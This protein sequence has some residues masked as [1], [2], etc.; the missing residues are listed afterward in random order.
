MRPARGRAPGDGGPGRHVRRADRGARSDAAEGGGLML[1]SLLA[2]PQAWLGPAWPAVWTL[3]KIVA[4]VLPLLLCVAYLTLW[5]RKVIG[6]IQ[7][8]IGPNG[9]TFFGIPWL[10][11]LHKPI[12]EGLKL[13]VK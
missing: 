2:Y 13:L 4:I 1:D 3:V 10:G 11:G 6:W 8:R 7:V 12:A 5:E 9:V